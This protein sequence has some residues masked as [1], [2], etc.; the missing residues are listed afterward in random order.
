M[1]KLVLYDTMRRHIAACA[2]VDEAK[3]NPTRL[4]RWRPTPGNATTATSTCG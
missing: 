2:R 4:R 3:E 1:S